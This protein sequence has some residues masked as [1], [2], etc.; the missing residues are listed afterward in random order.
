MAQAI[1]D[2]VMKSCAGRKFYV[3]VADIQIENWILSDEPMIR[4]LFNVPQFNYPGDGTGSKPI[5]QKISGGVMMGPADKAGLLKKSSALTASKVSPSL[6]AFRS[7][8][9]FDW[10]WALK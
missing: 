5:L 4:S 8:I 3:G 10:Y 1:F 2:G 7:S 6:E 9:D